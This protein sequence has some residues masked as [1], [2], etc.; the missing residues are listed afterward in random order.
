MR[1]AGPS[2]V[3]LARARVAWG[4]RRDDLEVYGFADGRRPLEEASRFLGYDWHLRH[5][6]PRLNPPASRALTEDKWV[7]YRLVAGFDLPVPPTLGLFDAT[8]GTSW[9]GRRPMRTVPQ[10]LAEVA[11]QRPAGL[12]LKPVGGGQGQ[13]LLILDEVDHASGRAVTRT[14]RATTL[15]AAV[16]G[17]DPAG[18][19]GYTGYVVQEP[20]PDH[21]GLHRIAPTTTNTVRVVTVVLGDGS[22]HVQA[23]ML[24]L[25]RTGR[26]SDNAHAGG[27]TVGVDTATGELGWG[28]TIASPTHLHAHPDTGV[29]FTG[30][31][32]PSWPEVLDLCRRA[33]VLVHGLR[34]VGWD[35]V[36][37]PAGP[38][39]LEGNALWGL[40]VQAHSDGWLAD[41]V[42]RGQLEA[43]GVPLPTGSALRHLPDH[44]ASRARGVLRRWA[45]RAFP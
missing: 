27:I 34:S 26:M 12:V 42:V 19:R 38:V 3:R 11:R 5:V 32:L 16:G 4:L 35:V 28:R 23:A 25:G 24:R 33:A 44:L 17:L 30:W 13:Q 9:D 10:V 2:G 41:P 45:R 7:F 31:V 6:R 39:L 8:F 18:V 36:V 37:T 1:G 15:E 22:A 21:P 20:V 40:H 29:R 14:G 43:L